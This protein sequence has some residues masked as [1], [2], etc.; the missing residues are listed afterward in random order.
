MSVSNVLV[1]AGTIQL[2]ALT[3]SPTKLPARGAILALHGGGS[4]ARYW[5]NPDSWGTS[6]L[7]LGSALGFH[8]LAVDRPGYGHSSQIDPGLTSLQQQVPILFEALQSWCVDLKFHGPRFVMGHSVGAIL[9]TMMAAHP[10]SQSLAACEGVGV[11]L[12]YT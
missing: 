12:R 9:A 11:A 6:L 5:N 8:V 2:S 7:Q 3:A 1:N 10:R 4:S